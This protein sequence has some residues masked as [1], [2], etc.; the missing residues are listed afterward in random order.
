MET[1]ERQAIEWECLKL[2]NAFGFHLDQCDFHALSN[3]FAPDGVWTRHDHDLCGPPQIRDQLAKDGPKK[4][5]PGMR[6]GMHFVTNFV[7]HEV[8][9]DRVDSTC[10]ALVISSRDPSEGVKRFDPSSNIQTILYSDRFQRTAQGWRFAS[11]RGHYMLRSPG[12]PGATG[13]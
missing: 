5:G 13:S 11:R 4:S 6:T 12:W 3:L 1:A 10:Y 8:G 7:P 2:C 9:V